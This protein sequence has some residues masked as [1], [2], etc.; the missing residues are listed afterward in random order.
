MSLQQELYGLTRGLSEKLEEPAPRIV[1]WAHF[2]LPFL[3][4]CLVHIRGTQTLRWAIYPLSLGASIWTQFAN[5]AWVEP[6]LRIHIGQVFIFWHTGPVT[7]YILARDPPSYRP[8][9][10]PLLVRL[11][12]TRL[13]KPFNF[14]AS[15]MRHLGLVPGHPFPT[16]PPRRFHTV[17]AVIEHLSSFFS[18][19]LIFELGTYIAFRLAPDTIGSPNLVGGDFAAWCRHLAIGWG[20]PVWSVWAFWTAT[21]LVLTSSSTPSV[22]HL[23]A[24]VSIALGLYSPEEWPPMI[25]SPWKSTSINELWG[26]RHHQ[27]L[28]DWMLYYARPFSFFR[29]LH[30]IV[31]FLLSM[32][33]HII[34]YYPITR[35]LNLKPYLIFY[36]GQ[37]LG[38]VIERA[39]YKRT[40]R[41][42]GGVTGW[43]WTCAFVMLTAVPMVELEYSNG[44]AGTMRDSLARDRSLS[45]VEWIVYLLGW[46]KH[47]KA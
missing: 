41:R 6:V 32:T 19:L 23:L 11:R 36:M 4:A 8:A 5:N 39:Y 7:R 17:R 12:D 35:K 45:P 9:P 1:F 15:Q 40:G 2:A 21:L 37:G 10:P 43:I 33:F 13:F 30:M 28:K 38:C 25:K 14:L 47:P 29:P 46:G 22:Y 16:R 3:L 20:V 31:C 34:L 26:K 44:W 27:L 24:A 42:V 18:Y